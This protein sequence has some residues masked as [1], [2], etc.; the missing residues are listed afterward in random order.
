MDAYVKTKKEACIENK[1]QQIKKLHEQ[2]EF[3]Q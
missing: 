1:R 3:Y 2:L